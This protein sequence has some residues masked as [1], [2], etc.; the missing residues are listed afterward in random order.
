MTSSTG[1]VKAR[2]SAWAKGA[3][4]AIDK[5]GY[6]TNLADNLYATLSDDSRNEFKNGD[7]GELG[8]PGQ[9][10]K[11]QA[12]HSSSALACNV[13][14]YW[15]CR[16]SSILASA[17]GLHLQIKSISFEQKFPTGL[18][19]NSPN[20]DVVLILT[21]DSLVAVESKF[22]E[23]YS[24]H[25]SGFKPKYFEPGREIWTQANYPNCQKLAT[26]LNSGEVK[27]RWL[28]AE[29]LLKHIL[30]LTRSKAPMWSLIYLWYETAGTAA[31]EHAA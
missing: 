25:T 26:Q 21:D 22:L 30:G 27:L 3:C 19:G 7:G 10:G 4:I 6:T 23:P 24:A 12:L 13:F 31:Q 15:R 20:L 17:L 8:R 1:T 16:D 14:E 2:Q 5:D 11:M 9:R 28:N 29:Q 18:P